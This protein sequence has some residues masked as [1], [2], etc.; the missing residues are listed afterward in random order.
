MRDRR[1][2]VTIQQPQA[3]TLTSRVRLMRPEVLLSTA[4][5]LWFSRR[6]C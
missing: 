4:K 3:D 5:P 1:L 6:H 2:T